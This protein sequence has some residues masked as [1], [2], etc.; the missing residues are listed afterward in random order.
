MSDLHLERHP[1]FVPQH[2][3]EAQVLVLAGDIG[4]YQAGSALH[5][6]RRANAPPDFGLSR[7][8][9]WPVPVLYVPGNHEYDGLPFLEARA[10]LRQAAESAGLVWLDRQVWRHPSGTLGVRFLG[11][12][13]WSDFDALATSDYKPVK[14]AGAWSSP[15]ARRQGLRQKSFKAADHWLAKFSPLV[16]NA[17]ATQ[18]VPMLAAAM[19]ELA[20]PIK[21]GSQ[22]PW[23]SPWPPHL[24][25]PLWSPTSPHHSK[26]PTPA[27][28]FSPH[29]P[30]SAT[31]CHNSCPKPTSGCTAT[32]MRRPTTSGKRPRL[33]TPPPEWLPT[34]AATPT[35]A[36]RCTSTP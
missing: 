6:E 29:R 14:K 17:G 26:A 34:R 22:P 5:A 10:H 31:N 13:L 32:S 19:R 12:T 24:R 7:F 16:Q 25:K 15:E 28:A 3:P 23:Q 18:L 27:T 35:K 11:C 4:S 36:S 9:H 1:E 21:P 33:N 20:L 8:A 30:A 2:H